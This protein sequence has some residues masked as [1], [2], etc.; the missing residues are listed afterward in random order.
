MRRSKKNSKPEE[1]PI[2]FILTN[3]M[4][5][6]NMQT[7][8]SKLVKPV[9]A[10]QWEKFYP[11]QEHKI[12]KCIENETQP[13]TLEEFDINN[14]VEEG[15]YLV[16]DEVNTDWFKQL[17]IN[18]KGNVWILHHSLSGKFDP[19]DTYFTEYS[20]IEG[21]HE[22]SLHQ[23]KYYPDIFAIFGDDEKDK[24]SR[25]IK[26]VLNDPFEMETQEKVKN[27]NMVY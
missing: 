18:K 1:R 25:I 10:N 15:I 21:H 23:Q 16:W 5:F 3:W 17:K 20:V 14:T 11:N 27:A 26:E 12:A 24:F 13:V 8:R 4:S 2:V 6:Q 19:K 9:V 7:G 22:A